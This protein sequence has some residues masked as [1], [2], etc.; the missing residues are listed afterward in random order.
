MIF[1]K[2]KRLIYYDVSDKVL[3]NLVLQDHNH[4]L[5][6]VGHNDILFRKYMLFRILGYVI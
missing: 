3:K 1:Y 5:F 6:S 4:I 2:P